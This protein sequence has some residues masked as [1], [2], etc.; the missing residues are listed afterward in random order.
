ME[1]TIRKYVDLACLI[2]S[3][4]KEIESFSGSSSGVTSYEIRMK[5]ATMG[6]DDDNYIILRS[7]RYATDVNGSHVGYEKFSA[8]FWIH[9]PDHGRN[10]KKAEVDEYADYLVRIDN[11][12]IIVSNHPDESDDYA[13]P[14]DDFAAHY[15]EP[16]LSNILGEKIS[17]VFIDGKWYI[18][19]TSKSPTEFLSEDY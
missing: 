16:Y 13:P 15:F 8:R 1:Y 14:D 7:E 18:V 11:A 10:R 12:D 3:V 4:Q 2:K 19:D 6:W 9:H 17:W 5:D